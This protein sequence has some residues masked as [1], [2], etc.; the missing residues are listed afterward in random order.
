VE[1][2]VDTEHFAGTCYRAANWIEIGQTQGRGRQDREHEES[3]SI[4]TIYVYELESDLRTRVGVVAPAPI[5]VVALEIAEG[6]DGDEWAS[7][8]FGGAILGDWRLNARLSEF[9][10]TLGDKPGRAFCGA[11]QGDKAAIKSY[12]RMIDQPDDSLVTMEAILAPHQTRTVQRMKAQSTVLCIQDGTDVN[13]SGLVQC[14]RLGVI[15]SNQTGAKSGGLHLHS[16]LVLTTG[17]LP[18]GVLGVQCSA[19]A[20]RAKE[21]LRLASAIPIEEKKTFAWIEGLRQ[22]NA[23]A[24]VLPDTRQICVMDREAD[25]FELFDAQRQNASVDLLVRAKHDRATSEE[26]NLFESARQSPVQS[27]LLIHVP[28]QS[29]RAK[30]SKHKARPGH[31]QRAAQVQLRYR[32]VEFRPPSHHPGKKALKLWVVHVVEPTPPTEGEPL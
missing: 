20:P 12:Y 4:K 22:C 24:A 15:G 17:G 27:Q 23:L 26:L 14:E 7:H 19:P 21:D 18:L 30:K 32:E 8:E 31:E 9:A 10:R 2:F 11:A 6:L 28:R 29:A 1:S 3:K 5:A 25:F 16:T 13:Y